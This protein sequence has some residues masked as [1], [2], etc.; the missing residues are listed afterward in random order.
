MVYFG[1]TLFVLLAIPV[2]A[3]EWQPLL[4]TSDGIQIFKKEANGSGLIEFRGSGVVMAPLPVVA[5]VIFNTGRRKEWIEGLAESW[6]LRWQDRDDYIEYDHIDMPIF[7]SDRDFVSQVRIGFDR[8]GKTL[9]FHYQAAD[10]PGAPHTGYVRGEVITM[11]FVLRSVDRDRHTRIDAQFLCDPKGWIPNWL[12][13]YFLKDWPMTTFR[14]LRKEVLKPDIS[15]D[16]RIAALLA[17]GALTRNA[18]PGP[19]GNKPAG[20]EKEPVP[21]EEHE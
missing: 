18:G 15:V 5:T 4:T 1:I 9:A 12:V 6:V 8:S 14:S 20:R 21:S 7:F 13:N 11:M 19:P 10:D 3:S 17:H 2:R 16:P